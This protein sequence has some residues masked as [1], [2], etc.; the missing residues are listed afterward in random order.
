MAF[1]LL[2]LNRTYFE[3]L[4]SAFLRFV[5]QPRTFGTGSDGPIFDQLRTGRAPKPNEVP[6]QS[7]ENPGP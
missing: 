7:E 1:S 5:V 6:F 3:V 2:G 4:D